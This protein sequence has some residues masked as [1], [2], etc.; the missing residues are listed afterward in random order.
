[1][2][3]QYRFSY[4]YTSVP[5]VS[6]KDSLV[7][8]MMTLD[9]DMNKKKSNFYSEAKVQIDSLIENAN[10]SSFSKLTF[11]R[12]NPNL[13]YNIT[14][15][16]A[17]NN[18]VFHIVYSGIKMKITETEKPDWKIENETKK[19]ADYVCKK[20]IAEYKG[21]EWI[22]WFTDEI[23][24]PDGPYKFCGLPGLIV[25]IYDTKK[26]H[27][28]SIVQ[29]KKDISLRIPEYKK[30]EKEITKKQLNELLDEGSND[31]MQN[32]KS[33]N[34]TQRGYSLLLNDGNLLQVDKNVKP[35]NIEKEL[36]R[37]MQRPKNPI[38]LK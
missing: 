32:I 3:S 23:P 38:E 25:E 7:V 17:E 1:V 8:D 13:I 18:M 10:K 35:E 24:I 30:S 9:V 2:F 20:A 27:I 4:Q 33:M 12:Y 29:I 11:P 34:I 6:K 36:S 26:E 28:F 16:L 31:I 14:K 21:R 19:I 37:Q 5:D 15:D 22:A